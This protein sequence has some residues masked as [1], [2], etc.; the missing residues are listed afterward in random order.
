MHHLST[1][2]S[3]MEIPAADRVPRHPA[4]DADRQA[5]EKGAEGGGPAPTLTCCLL[6][7][8]PRPD[9]GT[10]KNARQPSTSRRVVSGRTILAVGVAVL[11]IVDV[12][13]H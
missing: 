8:D 4:E 12:P 1:K 2:L 5:V 3:R 11:G 10:Q 9:L 13:S 6:L 7:V